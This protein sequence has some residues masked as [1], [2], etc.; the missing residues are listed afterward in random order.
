M[1]TA[2]FSIFSGILS[3]AHLQYHLKRCTYQGSGFCQVG[4]TLGEREGCSGVM[5]VS[6]E[7]DHS[8]AALWEAE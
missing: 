3:T 2:E 7:I 4:A 1:A 8:V 5:P 6:H